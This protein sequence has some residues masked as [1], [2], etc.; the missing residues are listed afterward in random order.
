MNWI[1]VKDKLPPNYEEVIYAVLT[2]VKRDI[3]VGHRVDDIWYNCYLLYVSTPLNN[4]LCRVTHW[5]A[6]PDYPTDMPMPVPSH[7]IKLPDAR[8]REDAMM[9]EVIVS[10]MNSIIDKQGADEIKKVTEHSIDYLMSD[11]A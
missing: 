11:L 2:D 10:D 5:I 1:N 9:K 3:L 4:H 7:V 8:H 6:L